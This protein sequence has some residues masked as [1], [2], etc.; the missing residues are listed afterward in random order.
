MQI[1]AFIFLSS[2][3]FSLAINAQ[4][5]ENV[6]DIF[7][8]LQ[9]LQSELQS[10]RAQSEEQQQQIEELKTAQIDLYSVINE[11]KNANAQ[12]VNIAASNQAKEPPNSAANSAAKNAPSNQQPTNLAQ[13]KSYYDV[14]F[15]LVKKRDFAQA[16]AALQG[17]I[18][19]FPSGVYI[20]H[21]KYWL[22][23][24]HL[25]QNENMEAL[26]I[27]NTFAQT[28]PNSPK[29]P[30]ALYKLADTHRKL[31]NKAQANKLW[32]QVMQQ[33]PTSQAAKLAE[34]DLIRFQ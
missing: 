25:A 6:A 21:A 17:F 8:Q 13:E 3:F 7:N 15:E 26:A 1:K 32:Q 14:A 27:F 22:G 20:S 2:L 33:Y 4:E 19:R 12:N 16:K 28:Y 29:V 10:L 18:Q 5:N 11:L 9:D 24:V 34:R 23:E 30:D 31:G